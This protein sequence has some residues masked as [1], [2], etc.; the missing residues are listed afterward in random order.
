[1]TVKMDQLDGVCV[2][3]GWYLYLLHSFYYQNEDIFI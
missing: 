2:G 3:G 1:M